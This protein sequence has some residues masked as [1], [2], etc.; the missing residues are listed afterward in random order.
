MPSRCHLASR[1]ATLLL[2]VVVA[3]VILLLP[4]DLSASARYTSHPLINGSSELSNGNIEQG[5]A[6]RNFPRFGFHAV[7]L[8]Q[9]SRT[10]AAAQP[11][12]DCVGSHRA[13]ANSFAF[14]VRGLVG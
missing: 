1:T 14:F 9:G 3:L 6:F 2:A 4:G 5:F 10:T 13:A 12:E 8:H 11:G 7:T